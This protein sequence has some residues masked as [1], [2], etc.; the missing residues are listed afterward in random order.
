M[1]NIVDVNEF[2]IQFKKLVDEEIQGMSLAISRLHS[3][4]NTWSKDEGR[5]IKDVNSKPKITY[6]GEVYIKSMVE[7]QDLVLQSLR[8]EK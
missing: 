7:F 2:E 4:Q 5:D 6:L 8:G 1:S 3:E